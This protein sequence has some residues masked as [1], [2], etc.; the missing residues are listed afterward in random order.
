VRILAIGDV[1]GKP[2]RQTVARVLPQLRREREYA[3]V[4]CNGENAAGGNGLTRAVA[5]ELR[6]LLEQ[7]YFDRPRKERRRPLSTPTTPPGS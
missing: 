4:V 1:V 3:L 7:V 5:E 2:G 6:D